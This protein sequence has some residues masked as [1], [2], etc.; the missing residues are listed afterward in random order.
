MTDFFKYPNVVGYGRGL[1]TRGGERTLEPA[2]VVLVREKL[3]ELML[4]TDDILPRI[5]TATGREVDVVEVGEIRALRT[6]RHRPAPG[7]VSIGHFAITAGTLGVVVTDLETERLLIL[8]NNHVLANSNN[9]SIGDDIYQPGPADGGGA[10]DKLAQLHRF[11]PIN[12]AGG[13]SSLADLLSALGNIFLTITGNACRLKTD[14]PGGANLV[15]AALA[16]PLSDDHVLYSIL[17]IGIV[18]ETTPPSLNQR[19]RKSGRTTELTTGTIQVLDAAVDVSYGGGRT[20]RFEEQIITSEMSQG[21]DSGSLLVDA[22]D[23]LAV[24]LLFAGSAQ[25]TVHNSIEN[26]L[27]LLQVTL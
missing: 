19:V 24:G 22:E 9:A 15:D 14:C 3:P 16:L 27:R 21:G 12:F 8:S 1:S 2:T 4:E 18:D 17:S 13:N 10:S 20:A 26:V 7:G 5:D 6:T 23:N 11:V 25:V